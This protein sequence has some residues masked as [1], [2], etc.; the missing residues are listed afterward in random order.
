MGEG[1]DV[2]SS[3]SIVLWHDLVYWLY[4]VIFTDCS[5][6][7]D[8]S[9]NLLLLSL[10]PSSSLVSVSLDLELRLKISNRLVVCRSATA[11]FF[12]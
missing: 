2:T 1:L 3:L 11:I 12:G 5:I 10:L 8:T 9:T 4:V 7:V 6:G